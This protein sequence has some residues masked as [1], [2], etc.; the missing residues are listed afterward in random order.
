MP[1]AIAF[2]RVAANVLSQLMDAMDEEG[3]SN[4][5]FRAMPF[6]S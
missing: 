5:L 3:N 4:G 1:W 2:G 6:E